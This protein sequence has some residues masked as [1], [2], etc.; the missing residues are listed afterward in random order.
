M[1]RPLRLKTAAL[2]TLQCVLLGGALT[3]TLVG[4]SSGSEEEGRIRVTPAQIVGVY[5]LKLNKGTELL[6]L[7]ADGTY[8]QDTVSQTGPVHHTGQWRIK[9][10]L[11]DGSEVILLNAAI[12]PF[13]NAFKRKSSSGIWRIAD[14]R[15]RT[16][17]QSGTGT[18]RRRRLVLC[19]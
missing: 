16:L 14:V 7:K 13:S 3:L 8:T 11:F 4:C 6:E 2:M 18:K 17:W 19:W 9:K 12:M 5:E 15:P 1:L 10:H